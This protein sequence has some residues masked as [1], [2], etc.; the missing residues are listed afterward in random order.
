MIDKYHWIVSDETSNIKI[1]DKTMGQQRT[2]TPRILKD[3]FTRETERIDI[4]NK[5][6]QLKRVV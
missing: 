1:I 4:S 5:E 6:H 2:K 3:N